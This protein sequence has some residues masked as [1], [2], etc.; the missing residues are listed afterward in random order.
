MIT[1]KKN[2]TTL[3]TGCCSTREEPI[4]SH[5]DDHHHSNSIK[6]P[7]LMFLWVNVFWLHRRQSRQVLF[8]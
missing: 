3:Q 6:T 8:S 4:H 1:K 2:K 7:L 5:D